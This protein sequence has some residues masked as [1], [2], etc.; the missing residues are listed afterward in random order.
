MEVW[1]LKL[2][3]HSG[4]VLMVCGEQEILKQAQEEWRQC[5]TTV[6]D[7]SAPKVIT[8][9]GYCDTADRAEVTVVFRPDQYDAVSLYKVY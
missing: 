4:T 9:L 7:G 8:V 5:V 2:H 1:G 6:D 3:D